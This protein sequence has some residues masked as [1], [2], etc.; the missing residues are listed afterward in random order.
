MS[1]TTTENI[2]IRTE[3]PGQVCF[4]FKHQGA[5]LWAVISKG[6]ITRLLA[7]ARA[8]P[9]MLKTKIDLGYNSCGSKTDRLVVTMNGQ[10]AV[11]VFGRA[12]ELIAEVGG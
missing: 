10:D 9:A 6:A 3:G 11:K 5:R 2:D 12:L 4:T 7:A 8:R 1:F